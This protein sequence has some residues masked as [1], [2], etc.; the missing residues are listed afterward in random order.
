M[1]DFRND[2]RSRFRHHVGEKEYFLKETADKFREFVDGCQ[3][4][5]LREALRRTH[6]NQ[7][8]AAKLMSLDRNT[9]KRHSEKFGID[10]ET[11]KPSDSPERLKRIAERQQRAAYNSFV[12]G[13]RKN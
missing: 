1:S 11:Y 5:F 8:R 7:L 9:F 6:G 10:Y 13:L 12:D 2:V 4:V 3:E